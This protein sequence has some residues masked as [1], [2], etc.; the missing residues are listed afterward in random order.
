MYKKLFAAPLALSIAL[1]AVAPTFA[2]AEEVATSTQEQ[3]PTTSEQVQSKGYDVYYK[4]EVTTKFD[5]N[6]GPVSITKVNN[7]YEVT[8]EASEILTKFDINGVAATKIDGATTVG[9]QKYKFTLDSISE[10]TPIVIGYNAGSYGSMTHEMGLNFS[11]TPVSDE[12][13][14]TPSITPPTTDSTTT[15]EN[16]E[17]ATATSVVPVI[18]F[19]DVPT[20]SYNNSFTNVSYVK[21]GDKYKV[22]MNVDQLFTTFKVNGK[23]VALTA[24]GEAQKAEFTLADIN[25]NPTITIAYSAGGYNASHDFTFDFTPSVAEVTTAFEAALKA[26]SYT[27]DDAIKTKEDVTAAAKQISAVD[28]IIAA[29]QASL[30]DT[31]TFETNADYDK[32]VANVTAY[33]TPFITALT[34]AIAALSYTQ[35]GSITTDEQLAAAQAQLKAATDAEA[36]ATAAGLTARTEIATLE[37]YANIA[38]QKAVVEAGV[39]KQEA[40]QTERSLEVKVSNVK[41]ASDIVKVYGVQKGDTVRVY[42]T[43]GKVVATET[44]TGEYVRF[45]GLN[46]GKVKGKV[47]ATA[48][49]ADQQESAKATVAFKAEPVSKAI[50]KASVT[51][52]NN[53]GKNDV[54]TVKGTVKGEKVRVYD[55][56]GKTLKTVTATGKTTK[57]SI[58]QLGKKTGKIQVARIQVG[59]HI[60]AKT[61]VKFSKEK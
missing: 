20:A 50:A 21:D 25:V 10:T 12:S 2:H 15:D 52:K 5:A 6:F 3:G 13:I 26:L 54:V 27:A 51:V 47:S 29:A 9:M 53:K 49:A 14:S 28:G 55:A 42:N 58:K 40:A 31:A 4:G 11:A 46:L 17:Q 22:T 30:V 36:A 38:A 18:S 43:K 57:V 1:S 39:T 19:K 41:G 48:Q 32:Q 16:K 7:K 61:T 44:A 59:K 35:A 33:K 24:D 8:L 23:D 37:N 45:A 56:N 60:S 34:S